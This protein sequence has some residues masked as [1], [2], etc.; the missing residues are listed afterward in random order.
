[1]PKRLYEIP[2]ENDLIK[3]EKILFF[4]EPRQMGKTFLSR[5]IVANIPHS[6]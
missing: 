2:C 1:M 3:R 4:A 5:L 6:N